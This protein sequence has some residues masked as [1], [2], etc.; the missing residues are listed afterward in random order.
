MSWF[1]LRSIR[2]KLTLIVMGTCAAALIMAGSALAVYDRYEFRRE[3]AQDLETLAR[4][5]SSNSAAA[6]AFND[7][8]AG[9][10]ILGALAE[11]KQ[12]VHACLFA[13]DGKVFATYSRAGA[14]KNFEP[15]RRGRTGAGSRRTD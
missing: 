12:I 7:A 5:T 11:Q 4:I 1:R 6:L 15:P 10:E 9:R 13:H 14:E 3:M 8:A 2:E